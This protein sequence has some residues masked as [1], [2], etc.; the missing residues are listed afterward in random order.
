M[1]EHKR[2]VP[3]RD[4]DL[5]LG[6]ESAFVKR[7]WETRLADRFQRSGPGRLMDRKRRF[8][9]GMG[10]DLDPCRQSD[11]FPRGSP[12][13]NTDASPCLRLLVVSYWILTTT[14][15][16]SSCCFALPV[17][18]FISRKMPSMTSAAVRDERLSTRRER[19]SSPNS[20]R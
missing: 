1:L 15:V 19:R 5:P 12:R 8:N 11:M 9:D 14:I 10:D 16:I 2:I 20:S 17:K 3:Y 18:D 7:E 6:R 13:S 4:D